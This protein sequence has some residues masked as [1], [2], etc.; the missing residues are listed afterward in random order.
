MSFFFSTS[1]NKD[2]NLSSK[3]PRNF[4]PAKILAKSREN[5][6]L[7]FSFSGTSLFAIL[8]ASPSTIAVFPTPGSPIKTGL[9]FVLLDKTCISLLISSSLPM[10]GSNCPL[11]ALIVKLTANLFNVSKPDSA[12]LFIALLPFLNFLIS[13]R[14]V[15]WVILYFDKTSLAWSFI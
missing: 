1:F 5:I 9:F 11:E 13:S 4:E 8:I 6:S 12:L 15:L 2:F 14:S 7:D 3:S 10:T